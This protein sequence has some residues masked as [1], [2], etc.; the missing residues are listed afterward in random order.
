[1]RAVL[2][3]IAVGRDNCSAH[4]PERKLLNPIAFACCVM[5]MSAL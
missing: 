1:M 4:K 3:R 5:D 2:L